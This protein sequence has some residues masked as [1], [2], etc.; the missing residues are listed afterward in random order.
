[1]NSL[2]CVFTNFQIPL[3]YRD[4][5]ETR[6]YEI[7]KQRRRD[8]SRLYEIRIPLNNNPTALRSQ[9]PC[10]RIIVLIFSFRFNQ[11]KGFASG[12]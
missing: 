3:N 1:M 4:G 5:S 11:G 2:G 6:L 7:R 8:K 10:G 9:R 12:W